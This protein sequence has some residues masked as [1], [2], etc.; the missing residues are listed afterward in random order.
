MSFRRFLILVSFFAWACPAWAVPEP[1]LAGQLEAMGAEDHALRARWTRDAP[2]VGAEVMRLDAAHEA[3]LRDIIG[4]KGWPDIAMVGKP[5]AQAAW[6]VAQHGTP[7]FLKLCLPYMKASAEQG[8]MP[9]SAVALSIDRDLMYDGKPQRYGSQF[10]SGADGKNYMYQ[11]E[12]EAHLDQRR[13]QVG[14]GP[15]AEYKALML[16][17]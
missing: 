5:A 13:A 1:E 3:A 7:E 11:V 4:R 9:W 6:L 10:R 17:K 8:Q 14:L 16:S 12:D 2:E 15:I